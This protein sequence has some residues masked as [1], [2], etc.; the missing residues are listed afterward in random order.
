MASRRRMEVSEQWRALRRIEEGQ[1]ITEML[2][3]S[4]A[5]IIPVM[6]KFPKQLNIRPKTQV[7]GRIFSCVTQGLQTGWKI[8]ILLLQL[9]GIESGLHA[10]DIYGCSDHVM[11]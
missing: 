11:W 3:F 10:Y 9:S 5:F 6:E 7:F 4:S 1:S 8:D 2:L